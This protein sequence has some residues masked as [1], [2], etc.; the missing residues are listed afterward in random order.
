MHE[1]D[2]HK[3][4]WHAWRV[5][6]SEL[7]MQDSTFFSPGSK[8]LILRELILRIMGSRLSSNHP[9]QTSGG[10]KQNGKI[11]TLLLAKL[12]WERRQFHWWKTEAVCV[13]VCVNNIPLS[14]VTFSVPSVNT[15]L[16]E[17]DNVSILQ[18]QHEQPERQKLK[19]F[20]ICLCPGRMAMHIC[21]VGRQA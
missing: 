8:F 16:S 18:L 15:I 1:W 4:G 11:P 2:I 7:L 14:V 6:F 3:G 13:C 10:R 5:S 21:A 9:R 19:G 17:K 20:F 12:T